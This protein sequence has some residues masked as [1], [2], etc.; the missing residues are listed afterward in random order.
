MAPPNVGDVAGG[1]AATA[2]GLTGAT[3]VTPSVKLN[4]GFEMP[5][6]GYG[7]WPGPPYYA[8]RAA[9]TPFDR[10]AEGEA[11]YEA[12]KAG[13][14]HFD[15]AVPYYNHEIVGEALRRAIADGLCERSDLFVTSKLWNTEWSSPGDAARRVC[16]ELGLGYL[17]LYLVHSPVGIDHDPEAGYGRGDCLMRRMDASSG[18]PVYTRRTREAVWA[19]MERV[20]RD[21][22]ARSIGVSNWDALCIH[23][24]FSY[25]G[26]GRLLPAVNQLEISPLCATEWRVARWCQRQ[27]IAVQAYCPLGGYIEGKGRPLDR[28]EV[29]AVAKAAGCTPAQALLRW[30]V[31]NGFVPI[32][33]SLK[34]ERMAQG[35]EAAAASPGW[36]LAPEQ[37]SELEVGAAGAAVDPETGAP[38][39][40]VCDHAK[41]NGLPLY[42]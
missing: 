25:A 1:A 31:N 27:G 26:E 8:A 5:R 42:H 17:D 9:G 6:M 29:K 40:K 2:A 14:R 10:S 39:T 28:P 13:Y 32:T 19:D 20:A 30:S 33:R 34:P 37:M 38:A 16:A 35:L 41:E 22:V 3:A 11:V 21:G 12:V 23:D 18:L 24:M 7:V 36:D 15:C 4:S